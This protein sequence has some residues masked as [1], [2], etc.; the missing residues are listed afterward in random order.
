M[1]YID[2]TRYLAIKDRRTGSHCLGRKVSRITLF[3]G[4]VVMTRED[5]MAALANDPSFKKA[6]KF[7]DIV[8]KIFI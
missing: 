1:D 7:K 5:V 8:V 2:L 6:N 4:T 3:L